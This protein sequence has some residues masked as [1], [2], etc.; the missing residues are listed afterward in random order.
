MT[1]RPRNSRRSAV[2]CVGGPARSA[3]ATHEPSGVFQG[4]W[5]N[6]APVAVSIAVTMNGAEAAREGPSTHSAYAVTESLRDRCELLW[7]FR[8][9]ILMGSPIGTYTIR[10]RSMPCEA[11][12]KRL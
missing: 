6:I 12:S 3:N 2:H 9:E 1:C 5:A 10:S 4:L 8:R 11:C 7:I